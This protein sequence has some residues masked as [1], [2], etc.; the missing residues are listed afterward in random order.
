ML[1]LAFSIAAESPDPRTQVGCVIADPR[2]PFAEVRGCN[3]PLVV[4]PFAKADV[5]QHAEEAAAIA[6]IGYRIIGGTAYCT[7]ASCPTC[8]RLLIA[9]GVRR[10]VVAGQIQSQTPTRW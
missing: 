1:R 5:T 4:G 9:A 6:A 7:W 2:N 3:R 8:A 10:V